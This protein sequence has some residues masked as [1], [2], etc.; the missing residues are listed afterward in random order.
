MFL[1]DTNI[2]SE[3]M[4]TTMDPKVEA[5]LN[6]SA[7]VDSYLCAVTL[8][9]LRFGYLRLPRGRRRDYYESMTDVVEQQYADRLLPVDAAVA[10]LAARA[11]AERQEQGMATSVPD[12]QIAGV[13]LAHHLVL[14][15][16]NI[17][18]FAG[19][20]GLRVLNPFES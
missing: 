18:D 5:W 15:T 10:R 14:A 16:R 17:K 2:I 9:E 6:D 19:I 13:A 11:R 20:T 12:A 3:A 1:L 4:R 7:A 8:M